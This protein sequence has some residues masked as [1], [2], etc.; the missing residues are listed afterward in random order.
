MTI[1]F[2]GIA[3]NIIVKYYLPLLLKR[4]AVTRF[5]TKDNTNIIFIITIIDR[6][7]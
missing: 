4:Y 5:K 1:Y 3:L 2:K 7:F 6:I